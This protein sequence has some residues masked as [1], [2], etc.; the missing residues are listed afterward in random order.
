[1]YESHNPVM[2]LKQGEYEGLG[3]GFKEHNLELINV[4]IAV[5]LH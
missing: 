1:M 5:C 4:E 3:P 2:L